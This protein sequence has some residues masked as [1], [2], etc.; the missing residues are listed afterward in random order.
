[1]RPVVESGL[2]TP[3]PVPIRSFLMNKAEKQQTVDSLSEQF[4]SINS[5]FLI[6]YRGLKVVMRRNCAA[7]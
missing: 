6:N 1:V 3:G 7:R 4:R 2:L 5:A